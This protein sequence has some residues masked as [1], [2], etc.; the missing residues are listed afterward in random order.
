MFQPGKFRAFYRLQWIKFKTRF[1][2]I[3][4]VCVYFSTERWYYF[5]IWTNVPRLNK[6]EP[7]SLSIAE[8]RVFQWFNEP[9]GRPEAVCCIWL[10]YAATRLPFSKL[11][12]IMW[13]EHS[14]CNYST[15]VVCLNVDT[16]CRIDLRHS[17]QVNMAF[18][19]FS[20]RVYGLKFGPLKLLVI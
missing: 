16:A 20:A 19:A 1:T 8:R 10:A 18:K 6:L 9:T 2:L 4:Y 11:L 14:T 5:E 15:L 7:L 13:A 17:R 12:L 3:Q